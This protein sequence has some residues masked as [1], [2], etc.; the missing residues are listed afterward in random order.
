MAS[1]NEKEIIE[2]EII[3]LKR[4][5]DKYD[6]DYL[7]VTGMIED[8]IDDRIGISREVTQL[9]EMIINRER[10]LEEMGEA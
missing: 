5:V 3:S 10:I 1:N 6:K 8:L 4:A 2:A 9:T 7:I